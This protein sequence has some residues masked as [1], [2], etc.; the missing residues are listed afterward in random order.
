MKITYMDMVSGDGPEFVVK[1]SNGVYWNVSYYNAYG[2]L[3]W[4]AKRFING[5]SFKSQGYHNLLDLIY[6]LYMGT[7]DTVSFWNPKD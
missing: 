2:M 3:G 1:D 5:E 7:V 4:Y 6:A